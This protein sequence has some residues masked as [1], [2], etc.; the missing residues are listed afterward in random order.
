MIRKTKIVATVGPASR[1]DHILS[2]L[3]EAGVDAF[4]FNFSHGSH[5]EH[6]EAYDKVRRLAR[7][8][9]KTIALIQDLQGPKIRVGT[10]ETPEMLVETGAE[11]LLTSQPV[12]GGSGRIPI[13]YEHLEQEVRPNEIILMDDGK[14][15]LEAVAVDSEGVRCRVIQGGVL[16]PHKGVNFPHTRLSIGSCTP[17]DI[18]DLRFGMELGFDVVA[19]SFVAGPADIR[20]LRDKMREMGTV[21][22]I[23][24]KLERAACLDHLSAIINEADGVMV[25]RG[26]LGVEVD[27]KRVPFLQK[28]IIKLANEARIP[29]ITATQML[30]S[31]TTSLLPTRAEVADIANAVLDGTDALMLSAETSLGSYPVQAVQ[32]MR[33]I[34]M[35][36]ESYYESH[37]PELWRH[38]PLRTGGVSAKQCVTPRWWQLMIFDSEAL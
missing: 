22:P 9:G 17:K 25:A 11:V 27:I 15:R 24:A 32:M 6:A 26:D 12:A 18:K 28:T 7:S 35:E 13:G 38:Q 14:L 4:R 1:S 30:E 37:A 10:L 5:E 16:K 34:A 36:A 31:M 23:I 21:R 19:L 33:N 3:I 29:V 2:S 8:L 20:S